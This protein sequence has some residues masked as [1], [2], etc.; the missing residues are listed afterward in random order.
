LDNDPN[1]RKARTRAAEIAADMDSAATLFGSSSLNG[2]LFSPLLLYQPSNA[3]TEIYIDDPLSMNCSSKDD[4]TV[5]AETLSDLLIEKHSSSPHF[6]HFVEQFSRSL[7]T[8]VKPEDA[9]KVRVAIAKVVEEKEKAAKNGGKG[10][11]IGG[12]PS[13]GT[14]KALARGKEDLSSF[15]EAL[16]DDVAANDYDPDDDFVSENLSLFL[17]SPSLSK[18]QRD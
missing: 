12:K 16:D 15:G 1:A 4:F 13:L 11:G 18:L 3:D 5:L 6:T 8:P 14:G 10:V 7:L 17:S 9:K 2:R